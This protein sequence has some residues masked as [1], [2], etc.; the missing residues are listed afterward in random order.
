MTH[1]PNYGFDRLAPYTFES[2]VKMVKC[3]TNLDLVTK[4]PKEL[5]DV[6]FDMYPEETAAIWGVRMLFV[7]FLYSCDKITTTSIQIF[8]QN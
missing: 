3:W 1:M 2:V 5:A 4:P 8:C 6:Y 7:Y